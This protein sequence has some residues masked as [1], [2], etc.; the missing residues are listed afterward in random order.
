MAW[1]QSKEPKVE[2][3]SAKYGVDYY[4]DLYSKKRESFAPIRMALV[5]KE[6][7]SKTGN[8]IDLAL[9]HTDKEIV[10]LDCDNSAQNT[11]DYLIS[12]GDLDANRIRVI[13]MVDEMDDAMWNEDNTT[14]WVAVV[15]K[16]EWF[17][18][19]I[20]ESAADIGAVIL[21]GGST[22]LKWC[23]FVM[24]DRLINRGIINDESD[25]FNQKE[26]RERN[27]IF[28]GVLNRI[29]ALPIP[30]IFFTFHLKDKKQFMDIGN[31]TKGLMKVGEIV[32][33]IDGTQRFVSQQIFLKRYTK[34]GDKASGVEAD[35]S[36]ADDEFVIR[37]SVEEMKGR[38][39]EHLGKVYDVMRVKGGK[40]EW[41]GLPLRW[42]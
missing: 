12:T 32:D 7:T 29:T 6:N 15:E 24:T 37:A 16:L 19:F 20:G 27:R 18:N 41:H 8:A 31:G 5:G 21:D 33:W 4:R 1:A 38:N 40:V 14:N 10:V 22:F 36:L 11:I 3:A 23:E 25:N 13:P 26:W 30:Y 17:T 39:M 42:D 2:Q 34:K 35:K 28:K 9:K